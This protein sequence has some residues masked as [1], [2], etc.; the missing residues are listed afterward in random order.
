MISETVVATANVRRDLGS[1][2]AR[3]ALRDVLAEEP[4]LVGLQE[5]G[6]RRAGLLR[7]TG[8]VGLVPRLPGRVGAG[9]Y[10]WS[11][12]VLGG[13]AVGARAGRYD[14][15][16]VRS[17]VLSWPGR[18]DKPDRPFGLEPPRVA[19]LAR[20]RDRVTGRIVVLIDYH[21]VPGVQSGGGYRDDRPLLAARHR[22]EVRRLE[23]LVAAEQARGHVVH[24]VGDANFD[25]LR[26]AGLSSAW[27]GRA[28][29]LGTLGE[30]RK[31]DDVHGPG[32]ASSVRVL[33]TAS[34]HKAVVVRRTDD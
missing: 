18:A 3:A 5:W 27:E 21:L 25:G 6:L 12:P 8:S 14:V 1:G 28:D 20:H 7:E 30:H 33:V 9:D 34:D 17:V 29:A 32:P 4:D 2:P 13:C 10:A 19:T 22:A 16:G 11:T 23:A 24:A 15:L 31:V 26:L